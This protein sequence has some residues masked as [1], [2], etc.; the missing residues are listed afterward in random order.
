MLL[1][2]LSL[3]RLLINKLIDSVRHQGRTEK[4]AEKKK[5]KNE[6]LFL[7]ESERERV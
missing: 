7:Q 3:P 2:F 5:K 4:P 1:M 6:R